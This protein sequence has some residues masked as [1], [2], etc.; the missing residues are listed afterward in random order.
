MTGGAIRIPGI[1]DYGLHS[2]FAFRKRCAAHFDWCGGHK[3]ASEQCRRGSFG[4]RDNQRQVRL[5]AGF[6]ARLHRG[7][8]ETLGK[9][10]R[11]GRDHTCSFTRKFAGSGRI[12]NLGSSPLTMATSSQQW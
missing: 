12:A 9:K 1:H 6:D 8:L 3:I 7:K 11:T 4:F 2:A 5:S 10:D